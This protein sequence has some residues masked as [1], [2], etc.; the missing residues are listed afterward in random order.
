[1]IRKPT[2]LLLSG[3]L[4]CSLFSI[5]AHAVDTGFSDVP[6]TAPYAQQVLFCKEQGITYGT[7]NNMFSP[8]QDITVKQ[9]CMMLL[10][11]FYPNE[12]FDDA[13]TTAYKK[14]WI[15]NSSLQQPDMKF[16]LNNLA[17]LIFYMADIPVYYDNAID[18]AVELGLYPETEDGT[19]MATRA[20]CAYLI[21]C[22]MQNTYTVEIPEEYQYLNVT[23]EPGYESVAV[24]SM[25]YIQIL[26]ESILNAWH[27]SG[28]DLIFG[29]ERIAQF[30]E[31][32]NYTGIVTGLY[33][34]DGLTLNSA[35][36]AI[37]EFGHFVYYE[38]DYPNLFNLVDQYYREYKD[39][40][41]KYVSGYSAKNAQEFF[42]ECFETYFGR[43]DTHN[44][45]EMME[46]HLPL[47]YQMLDDMAQQN[48]GFPA[49]QSDTQA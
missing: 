35:V 14:G 49:E 15:S 42:A 38:S 9:A 16:Q 3:L 33:H 22:L 1:M 36:S 6:E 48:W 19:R 32:E 25:A 43:N 45:T 30:I 2:T 4:A 7:G 11:A 46:E 34:S 37:H 41:E 39:D 20:D 40:A 26:P 12:T 31:E 18:T 47:M 13:V 29:N 23:I 8:D 44:P 28:K 27:N 5:P 10:R 17:N 21:G 24:K